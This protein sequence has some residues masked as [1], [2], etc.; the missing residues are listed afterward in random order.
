MDLNGQFGHIES[1]SST[2]SPLA[3][4]GSWRKWKTWN[5]SLVKILFLMGREIKWAIWTYS[6]LT[7][8]QQSFGIIWQLTHMKNLNLLKIVKIFAPICA[9]VMCV[10]WRITRHQIVLNLPLC[11]V[12]DNSTLEFIK[13]WSEGKLS[14]PLD[15]SSVALSSPSVVWF[16][17]ESIPIDSSA[18]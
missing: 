15:F 17:C 6:I 14:L 4:F 10:L 16:P 5:F 3:L 7:F 2:N 1:K 12:K 8:Y 9:G 18:S 13:N 11:I